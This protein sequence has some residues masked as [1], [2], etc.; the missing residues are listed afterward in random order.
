MRSMQFVADGNR[1]IGRST[2]L[3]AAQIGFRAECEPQMV[4]EPVQEE[5]PG[6]FCDEINPLFVNLVPS[7]QITTAE[8]EMKIILLADQ[9]GIPVKTLLKLIKRDIG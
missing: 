7:R 4:N 9:M 5:C 6:A 1:V 8:V 3:G 2:P